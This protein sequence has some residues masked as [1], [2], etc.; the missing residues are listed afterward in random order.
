[1]S[2][3]LSTWL[4]KGEIRDRIGKALGKAFD[5]D[6]FLEQILI[7]LNA[8]TLA[9]C[10]TESKFKAAH[11]CA[12]L[13]MLPSMQHV[14]LIPRK[15]KGV[16]EEVTVMPQWQGLAALML[17]HPEV[18]RIS[19]SLVHPGDVFEFDGTTQTVIRHQYDPFDDARQFKVMADIRG[20]YLTVFFRDDRP[21]IFHIVRAATIEKARKCAQA[22]NIWANWFE[23][24]CIKTLYRNGFARRVVPIDPMLNQMQLQAALAAE[25]DALGNEA[26]AVPAAITQQAKPVSRT[27]AIA[28][29][30]APQPAVETAVEEMT[31]AQDI[32]DSIESA[33][34]LEDLERCMAEIQVASSSELS[35]SDT[36]RLLK[37]IDA[38]AKTLS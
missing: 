27:A 8:P 30:V 5:P 7:A 18:K 20:G 15:L 38:K 10:S 25:D 35:K 29:K 26:S 28:Q 23:E 12:A 11:T 6:F 21:P 14:A 33:T 19:H 17:R 36:D 34:S 16:G 1:M 13:G 3:S 22:D 32:S 24:Q 2:T 9:G 37:A 31:L 4:A